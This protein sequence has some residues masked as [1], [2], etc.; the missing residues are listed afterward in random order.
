[1]VV[2]T[3]AIAAVMTL[4]VAVLVSPGTVAAATFLSW[5]VGGGVAV[6][7]DGGRILS[8]VGVGLNG[9]LLEKLR[10]KRV[11][12]GDG[13]GCT[14]WC[15]GIMQFSDAVGNGQF[16]EHGGNACG[17]VDVVV[18]KTLMDGLE[19]GPEFVAP[20]VTRRDIDVG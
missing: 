4:L 6:V 13:V 19:S 14:K 1:M 17:V 8:G 15:R 10:E 20:I 12:V 2:G 3:A 7:V 5:C 11:L 9:L 16:S 18:W